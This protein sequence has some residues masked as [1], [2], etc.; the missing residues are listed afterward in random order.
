MD[1]NHYALQ[2]I[3]GRNKQAV[4]NASA[5]LEGRYWIYETTRERRPWYVLVTGDYASPNEAL[6]QGR[7]LPA[8]LRAGGPFAK[9]FDRI[10][11]EMRLSAANGQP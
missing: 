4:I 3:A 11:T 5:A 7:R 6:R 9:T 1:P 2:V 10:Q 8:S